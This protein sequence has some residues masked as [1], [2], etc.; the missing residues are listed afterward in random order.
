MKAFKEIAG[1]KELVRYLQ[2]AAETGDISHAYLFTGASG[3]GKKLLAE[4]FAATLLCER[5]STEPCMDCASCKKAEAGNHPDILYITHE[6]AGITV[7]DIRE[8]VVS[9]VA[10]RPYYGPWKIYIMEDAEL[11]GPEAQNALLKSIEEPPA[12]VV[13][14]LLTASPEMLLPTIL[15]RCVKLSVKPVEDGEVRAYLMEKLQIPDYE[16]DIAVSFAQGSIG[17]A[18]EAAGSADFARILQNALRILGESDRM[19]TEAVTDGVQ[20]ITENKQEISEYLDIFQMWFRD[21][22]M[23]KATRETDHLVFRQEIHRIKD[24]AQE[25]SYENL[26]KILAG[27]EK[28]RA[29]IKA[30]VNVDLA[31]VLLLL[32]MRD[33]QD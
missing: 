32:N 11:M 25:R 26:E 4:T 3:S 10:V 23:M 5:G 19:D 6:K 21:V 28:T 24:Q 13:M 7:D 33:L 15:S 8:Q 1:Q 14:L 27:I 18:I 30:N 17:R 9:T 22:L 12:Y 29:R 31:L 16:A 2:N 20:V